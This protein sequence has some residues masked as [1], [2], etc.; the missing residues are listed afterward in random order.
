MK[1][2]QRLSH[3]V[4]KSRK[5]S[6]KIDTNII[7]SVRN[8]WGKWDG[9]AEMIWKQAGKGSG[10]WGQKNWHLFGANIWTEISWRYLLPDESWLDSKEDSVTLPWWIYHHP[11]PGFQPWSR[12]KLVL[13]AENNMSSW[14]A[15]VFPE[16]ELHGNQMLAA[17]ALTQNSFLLFLHVTQ[18]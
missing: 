4:R 14:L 7:R 2:S 9:K 3:T 1:G 17:W 10:L 18:P 15:H 16:A 13:P 11:G 5:R 12:R 8:I 6:M